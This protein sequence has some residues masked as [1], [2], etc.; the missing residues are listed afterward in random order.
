[1]VSE[2]G[3]TFSYNLNPIKSDSNKKLK[4]LG[5]IY[6]PK[7]EVKTNTPIYNPFNFYCGRIVEG[8]I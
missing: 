6:M 3:E 8:C 4:E 2:N 7:I 5:I 1:M